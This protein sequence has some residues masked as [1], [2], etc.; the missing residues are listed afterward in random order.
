MGMLNKPVQRRERQPAWG[1]IV[2]LLRSS[3]DYGVP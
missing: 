3:R 2:R 1:P